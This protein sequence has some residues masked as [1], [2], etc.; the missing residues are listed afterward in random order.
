MDGDGNFVVKDSVAEFAFITEFL[1]KVGVALLETGGIVRFEY[2]FLYKFE[3]VV[4]VLDLGL[5]L[6]KGLLAGLE[7]LGWSL[8]EN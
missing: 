5:F 1:F 7:I 3:L 8:R 6:L 2:L 4:E